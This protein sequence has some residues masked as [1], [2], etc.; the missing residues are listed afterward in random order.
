MEGKTDRSGSVQGSWLAPKEPGTYQLTVRAET[1]I[2][3]E[4]IS[5]EIQVTESGQILLTT[6]KPLYQP[7]QKVHIRALCLSRTD[8]SALTDDSVLFE[9]DDPKG[10]KVF[11]EEAKTSDFGIASCTFPLADEV[12]LGT[13]RVRATVKG[14]GN[15]GSSIAGAEKTFTVQRYVLPKFQVRMETD[16]SFYLP[17]QLIRGRIQS[18]YFFG[19]P[20]SKGQVEV[21]VSTFA[22]G[23]HPLG[24]L[25]GQ[26]DEKGFWSFE[27]RLPDR[28]VGLPLEGGKALVKLEASVTDG[29][30]HEER[31]VITVPVSSQ[32]VEMA[33]VPESGQL[34][35]GLPMKLFVVTTYPDGSPAP[36]TFELACI[37]TDQEEE[38]F[39][40]K[41][42]THRSGIGEV[43][44]LIPRSALPVSPRNA[45]RPGW[46]EG[47]F[48]RRR[49]RFFVGEWE[50][51]MVVKGTVRDEKG[52]V[53]HWEK[54]MPF[55]AGEDQ[56]LLRVDKGIAKVGDTLS[57][58]LLVRSKGASEQ[59]VFLDGIV[60]RQT[61][62][63]K[64]VEISNGRGLLSINVTPDLIGTLLLHA[65][66]ITPEGDIIRDT[67]VVIVQPADRLHI[68]VTTDRNQY[69]PG[70][71]ARVTFSVSDGNGRP[72]PSAIQLHIV[73][74]SLYAL[75]ESQ[76]G[77]ERL[78]FLLEEELLTPRYEVHGWE[79]KPVL[80]RRD[81]EPEPVAQKAAMI[82]LAAAS[83]QANYPLNI[84][85]YQQNLQK[86]RDAWAQ[87]LTKAGEKI[88]KAFIAYRRMKGTEPGGADPLPELLRERLLSRADLRDPLG[89]LFRI[90]KIGATWSDGFRLIS[91]G[92]DRKFGT[93]DDWSVF[94]SRG[95]QAHAVTQ[96]DLIFADGA[97]RKERLAPALPRLVL[98]A[99]KEV[100]EQQGAGIGGGEPEPVR[101]RQFFPETL[102]V[103]PQ[104]ITDQNGT[105][106]LQV[107]LADSITTWRLTALA[108]SRSGLLGST[109]A[110]IRVFQDFFVD[111][112]LPRVLTQGDELEVPAAIYNYLAQPQKV[113]LVFKAGNGLDLIGPAETS[114]TLEPNEVTS[115]AFRIRASRFG[116][117]ELTLFAY[118]EAMS[119][120]VKRTIEVV[121]DGKETMKNISDQIVADGKKT[122]VRE[123]T[124]TIPEGAIDGTERLWIK[125]YPGSFSQVMEGLDNLLRMPFGC[126]EQT[127]SVTYPNVLV[128]DYL[129]KTG[130]AQPETEMKARQFIT[131]GYQRLLTFEVPGGG[132]S[133]FGDPPAHQVLTAYGLLEF[134]D[135]AR[136]YSVDENLIGRT[137]QWLISQQKAD[138]S[139]EPDRHGIAEGAVNR[140][141]DI[142]RTTAYITWAVSSAG[143]Q[144]RLGGEWTNAVKKAISYLDLK[145]ADARDAYALAVLLNAAVGVYDATQSDRARE[146]SDWSAKRLAET[147]RQSDQ[148]AFWE[149]KETTPFY[150]RGET[151]DLET[152]ALAAYGILRKGADLPLATKALTYLI[153]RKDPFGTW[154]TTQATIWSLKAFLQARTVRA[155]EG[156]LTVRVN[157]RPVGQWTLDRK[158][159]DVLLQA[160]A[161]AAVREGENRL[162]LEFIGQG[163]V[164]FQVVSRFYIPWSLVPPP[165]R[166]PLEVAVEYDRTEVLTKETVTCQVRVR[167]TTRTAAKMLLVDVGLPPGFDPVTEDLNRLVERKTVQRYERTHRQIIFY[168]DEIAGNAT[169]QWEFRLR[170]RYP[171]RAKTAPTTAYL[172]Y[173]PERRSEF[174]PIVVR[175]Q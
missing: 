85:S 9:V 26:T 67:K 154:Q 159:A 110:P 1:S 3:R 137:V 64:T 160:D 161:G 24:E 65:Y 140:Q 114:L 11:R 59:P 144:F 5:Q 70:E 157:D 156:R 95:G 136:V 152:T 49:P 113:R 16:R 109:T 23:W 19:K 131:I 60:N 77:L 28:L 71:E 111:L 107:P 100:P 124:V 146:L 118:G 44:V 143:A 138:G 53:A 101:V 134:S 8:H 4:E 20:V 173:E 78:Y 175:S 61:V 135:M 151:G 37:T 34:K 98:Q 148:E 68:R 162:T 2:G 22:A 94:V 165:R 79:L 133:W 30:R 43:T 21:S 56:V 130:Q 54:L 63:T 87:Y 48:I 139:W 174:R 171:V 115:A 13:Y 164:V 167:N 170:A 128:L 76:P 36:T 82:L 149:T 141:S 99:A 38:V 123:A 17:G 97:V 88:H 145:R 112:D 74:E 6:D 27:F 15:E 106:S 42:K 122:A 84:S 91:A 35:V 47:P 116:V 126:F 66:R 119:D 121:P 150:G 72:V 45:V 93:N 90:E 31:S 52:S 51:T 12:T 58:D 104:L 32:P 18:D 96:Q 172:Y 73:D 168:I 142:L 10:N 132:F 166:E 129:R 155:A 102:L 57:C 69:K 25:K 169:V 117:H 55:S 29:A 103:V 81:R 147:A 153:R 80:L 163:S 120:A 39:R 89:F 108:N 127:S 50:T 105:A 46:R 40:A 33:L 158:T 86:V 14:R 75:A 7:G 62:F 41:G 83:P 125:V 92:V